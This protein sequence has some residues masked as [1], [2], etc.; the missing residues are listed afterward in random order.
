MKKSCVTLWVLLALFLFSPPC[1]ADPGND[2]LS[3][4]M[5]EKFVISSPFTIGT[6]DES[7]NITEASI[8]ENGE[9]SDIPLPKPP[10]WF[11]THPPRLFSAV[12]PELVDNKTTS[13]KPCNNDCQPRKVAPKKTYSPDPCKN[14]CYLKL[15]TCQIESRISPR[16][17]CNDNFM[18][19]LRVCFK[20]K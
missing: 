20:R 4:P 13:G 10:P 12:T 9:T 7:K 3:L 11:L 1:Q 8:Y 14:A 6:E 16:Q 2:D 18:A 15:D 17:E 19:C 5:K